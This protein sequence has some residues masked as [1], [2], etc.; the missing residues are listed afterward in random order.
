[1]LKVKN[2]FDIYFEDVFLRCQGVETL[3]FDENIK[4]SV[5]EIK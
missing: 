1:M 2:S 4:I 3:N 5:F